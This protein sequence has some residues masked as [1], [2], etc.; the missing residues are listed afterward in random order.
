MIYTMMLSIL[1]EEKK[2]GTFNHEAKLSKAREYIFYDLCCCIR[3]VEL[4]INQF[5]L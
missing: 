4:E 2:N 5:N 1:F 3:E